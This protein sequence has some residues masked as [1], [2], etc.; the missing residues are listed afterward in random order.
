MQRGAAYNNNNNNAPR[1]DFSWHALKPAP[2]PA[3]APART[4]GDVIFVPELWGHGTYTVQESI[5]I[6][7][8][9]QGAGVLVCW[10]AC[11][12]GHATNSAA[13]RCG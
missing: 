8:E 10:C 12:C 6:A 4:G 1:N 11:S 5:G 3:L 7:V 13:Q 2:A 9:F